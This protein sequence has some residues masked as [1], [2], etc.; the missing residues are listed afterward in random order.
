MALEPV[1]VCGVALDTGARISACV[2][3]ANR[4]PAVY[5]RPD[6]FVL[7][8]KGPPNL[9][10]AVGP[11]LCAG[12]GLARLE[13]VVAVERFVARFAAPS[14]VVDPPPVRDDCRPTLW[15]YAALP[16]ALG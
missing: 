2:A 15:G 6:E 14:L 11:H 12:A 7:D 8:R 1:E 10:L 3:A 16:V 13:A 5:D 4:D 9:S